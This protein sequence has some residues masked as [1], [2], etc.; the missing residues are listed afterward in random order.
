MPTVRHSLF[1]SMAVTSL[2]VTMMYSKL[3][4]K[5]AIPLPKED[6]LKLF[7]AQ[8]SNLPGWTWQNMKAVRKALLALALNGRAARCRGGDLISGGRSRFRETGPHC[9]PFQDS[10][11]Y[12]SSFLHLLPTQ[13]LHHFGDRA[14]G[15]RDYRPR[16]T[17]C[18]VHTAC[19]N[20]G[21]SR[22][23]YTCV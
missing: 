11:P 3:D 9:F 14:K 6:T 7:W 13:L 15:E 12:N 16:Q 4:L 20:N 21:S 1:R 5:Q 2:D 18:G 22:Y 17:S 23:P 8:S 19:K 10:S